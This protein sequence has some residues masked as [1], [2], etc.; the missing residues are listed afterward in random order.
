MAGRTVRA[1]FAVWPLALALAAGGAARAADE[2]EARAQAL[3]GY[4]VTT[5]KAATQRALHLTNVIFAEPA[6]AVLA[7]LYGA[8]SPVLPEARE[9]AARAT[10]GALALE[11]TAAD[12]EKLDLSQVATDRLE[13]RARRADGRTVALRFSRVALAEFHRFIAENPPPGARAGRGARI[14][15]VY[16][17]ADDC[18][19]CKSWEAAY[20]GHGKLEASAQW[21]HLRFTEV[22]LATLKQAFRVDDVP[23]RLRPVFEEMAAKGVRIHG[24]PSFVLLVND[25]L[26]AHAL[27]TAAFDTLV[28]VALRAAVRERLALERGR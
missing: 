8:P 12:G 21:K 6:V 4:W 14:E 16:I 11:V 18:S 7:G 26:R 5:S 22:K 19:L 23:P 28:H 24:V 10:G 3:L 13:G 27:G 9:I 20:L 25:R 15:L 17:G 1:R 2:H